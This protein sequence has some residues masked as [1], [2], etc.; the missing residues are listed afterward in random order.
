MPD[1]TPAVTEALTGAP[2][3]HPFLLRF[4]PRRRSLVANLFLEPPRSGVTVPIEA[5]RMVLARARAL[6]ARAES[7][8]RESRADV[9]AKIEKFPKEALDYAR[10]Q[11]EWESLPLEQR[12]AIKDQRQEAHK[13][14][15]MEGLP[16]TPAQLQYLRSLGHAGEAPA[17]RLEASRLIEKMKA[18]RSPFAQ[19]VRRRAGLEAG[20]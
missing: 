16:P 14:A 8:S 15:Y 6:A 13:A 17:D 1:T 2:E 12:R 18:A 20:K 7:Y 5:G 9:V 11:I 3:P 10:V 4:E 19:E